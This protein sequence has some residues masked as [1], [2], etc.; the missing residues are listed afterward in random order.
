MTRWALL[1]IA[2]APISCGAP[3]P[4]H[5][6]LCDLPRNLAGW[7]GTNVRWMG[8]VMGS[9]EH[10]YLLIADKCQRRGIRLDWQTGQSGELLAETLRREWREP[11]IVRAEVSGKIADGY[12][13]IKDV[14]R[15]VF[16]P[17]T[18]ER[19]RDYM[20]SRGF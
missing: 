14:H 19:E 7:S 4:Q 5:A 12:L 3:T 17:M 9:F 15:V 2:L 11:G 13:L 10:G 18:P 16:I 20:R 6:S 8:T 1:I